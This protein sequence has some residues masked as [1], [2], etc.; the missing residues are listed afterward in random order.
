MA[1]TTMLTA[2]N[3]ATEALPAIAA[4]WLTVA[5][6]QAQSREWASRGALDRL[7]GCWVLWWFETVFE[8]AIYR[9]TE[10]RCCEQSVTVHVR[11]MSRPWIGSSRSWGGTQDIHVQ[12]LGGGR[13]EQDCW[14]RQFVPVW[15]C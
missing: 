7:L 1:N 6:P 2:R 4:Q 12:K 11:S 13:S 14:S 10:Q 9:R 8:G 3:S 15:M 5:W